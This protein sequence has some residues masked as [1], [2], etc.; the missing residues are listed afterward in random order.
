[1]EW[2]PFTSSLAGALLGL[3]F[4]GGLWV[5]VRKGLPSS[6]PWLWFLPSF[7]VRSAA[8]VA[9]LLLL[10]GSGTGNIL[11]CT[12]GFFAS[13]AIVTIAGRNHGSHGTG[14]QGEG[15]I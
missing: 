2:T 13:K 3:L 5:T 10:A 11:W 6:R 14:G 9:G 1:M 15:C 8:V 4:F 12:A 7:L